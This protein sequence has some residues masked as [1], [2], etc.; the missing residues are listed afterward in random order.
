MK[1][2]SEVL[3]KCSRC[4]EIT[5]LRYSCCG[6]SVEIDGK[7]YTEIDLEGDE[8]DQGKREPRITVDDRGPPSVY[9]NPT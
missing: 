3:G 8:N 4:G 1:C 2:L 6:C 7:Y 9:K 5:S